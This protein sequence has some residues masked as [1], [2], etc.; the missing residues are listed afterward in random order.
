MFCGAAKPPDAGSRR[1]KAKDGMADHPAPQ[2]ASGY[3][4]VWAAPEKHSTA[5]R[6]SVGR[7][8]LVLQGPAAKAGTMR[9][10]VNIGA[11]RAIRFGY[12]PKNSP[13]SDK[14]LTGIVATNCAGFTQPCIRQVLP[15]KYQREANEIAAKI[16]NSGND[17]L[18][19]AAWKALRRAVVAQYG[20]KCMACGTTPKNPRMTHVDHIKPRKTHPELTMSFDNLQ[21]LCCRCNKAKGNKH[22]RDYRP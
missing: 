6:M 16:K 10:R 5:E 7:S 9:K 2:N 14:A 20:R 18:N 13:A 22:S 15:V 11:D 1:D 3:G 8:I 4:P 21:V 17:F 12:P 19:S